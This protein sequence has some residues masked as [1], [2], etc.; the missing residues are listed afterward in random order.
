MAEVGH[1]ATALSLGLCVLA[2][3]AAAIGARTGSPELVAAGRRAMLA[4]FGAASI[5]MAVL[6][7][8][9]YRHEF[10]LT[11][12]WRNSSRTTPAGYLLTAAWGGQEGSLLF[13]G[14]LSL[15]FAAA[16]LVGRWRADEALMPWFTVACALVCGFFL[17]LVTWVAS[18]FAQLAVIPA[19]GNGLNPLL[20]HPGMAFH[21]PAL[22]LGFTGLLV[23]FGL[24]VAALASGRL[25]A[26]WIRASRRW[27]LLA[28]AML[29]LGLALGARWAYDVLGWGGYW[30]WDPVENAALMPWIAATAFLHSVMVEERRGMFRLWNVVLVILAFALVIVGTF[31]TRAGLVSSVHAFARSD[32]GPYFLAFTAALL[33]ASVLLVAWRL[34]ALRDAPG[35]RVES[36]LSREAAFLGNNVLFVGMLF[37]VFWG[38]LFP[39]FSELA[40]G[41][42]VTVGPAYFNRLV[43][44]LGW[45]AVL[46]MAV[47]P[48]LGWRRTDRAGLRRALVAPAAS[49]LAIV[50]ALAAGGVRQPVAL[51]ALATC[52]FALLA[53]V[54]EIARG[55]L[56]RR[57]RGEAWPVAVWR[58]FARGRRRYGGYVVHVGVVLLA[59]G[60]VGNLFTASTEARLMPGEAL[61]VGGYEVVHRGLVEREEPDVRTQAAR[62]EVRRAGRVLGELQPA[63]RVFRQR[64]DQ[65]VTSPS[66]LRRAHED[67][68]ALLGAFDPAT[69]SATLKVTVNPMIGGVWWGLIVLVLGTLVAAW[70][71]AAERR[72]L[73]VELGRLGGGLPARARP[74]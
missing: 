56:A 33:V 21:P 58:L 2:A 54:G 41:E 46:L 18:P 59:T 68:Y 34:P 71:D 19:D 74:R 1:L 14:W 30:G 67:V 69:G 11:Y 63:R 20:Q 57:R 51:V 43:L 55:A 16:A 45:A 64:E 37:A 66:V 28:W 15:G 10:A 40:T 36:A 17:G 25:D 62:I 47:G 70:P 52:A 9:L 65:P 50:A 26:G 29:T 31:L 49:S 12:V 24:A 42:R 60:I 35:G 48:L 44:P 39:L 61:A 27:T 32:I 5:A 4:A 7:V 6:V 53:T 13:W 38:T 3:G 23:P 22:Y 72:V 73:D 8:A